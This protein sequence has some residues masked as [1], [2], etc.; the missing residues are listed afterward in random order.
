MEIDFK[1][2]QFA[3]CESGVTSSL[4]NH[5]GID[6]SEAMAFG[7]GS[8]L[9]FLYF[10]FV[11]VNYLPLISFRSFPGSIIQKA[12]RR[13]GVKVKAIK[14]ADPPQSMRALD[15]LLDQGIPVGLQV[16]VYWLPYFPPAYRFH[17]N[18]H[19]IVVYGKQNDEYLISD[20][21]LETPVRCS[22]ADLMKVR[23]SKGPLPPKG[24]MYYIT[25]APD[26]VKLKWALAAGIKETCKRMLKTPFPLLGVKG[27]RY[28]ANQVIKWP[29]KL[30][31]RKAAL[32]LGQI[33][34][35]QEEI[36]TGGAGFRFLFASFLQE[37]GNIVNNSLMRELADEMTQAG[38]KWREFALIGAR[39]CKG[40]AKS[41]ESYA[42]L[43]EILYDSADREE[44]IFK[45]LKGLRFK[46]DA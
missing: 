14:F 41:S 8:G 29:Q 20:P 11:K 46:P 3:H 35:M 6:F 42:L 34:R 2:K 12:A 15:T 44:T 39:N 22:A 21:V 1:H 36:G 17:F 23:F 45:K 37:A 16:G 18:A 9:F 19:N 31:T 10:P 38:D 25:H 33:I 13:L 27:I 32:Y 7:I 30:G 24:K 40:R 43:S 4:F 26:A 5:S 28:L